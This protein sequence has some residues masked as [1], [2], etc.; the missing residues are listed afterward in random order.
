M[1]NAYNLIGKTLGACRLEQI[2]GQGGSSVVYL[3][4]Q[5]R[6]QRQVAV[7]IL[8]P[9]Q[10]MGSL[11]HQQFLKRFEHEA[12]IIARLDHESIIQIF[13]YNEQDGYAYLIMPYIAGGNLLKVLTA[14]GRLSPREAAGYLVQAADALDYAHANNVIHR[15]LKPANF[16][17]RQNGRLVL[18]DFGIARMMQNTSQGRDLTTPSLLLG[19][20]EYMAPEM[21]RGE[22]VDHYTDIYELGIVL[23][24]LLSG[25]L[26]FVGEMPYAILLQHMEEP[27]PLLHHVY[28]DI[29]PTVDEIIQR[30]T[31]K[32]R[33]DRFSSV[34][35]MA[36]E[37]LAALV[38]PHHQAQNPRYQATS[39]LPPYL[40][41][42]PQIQPFAP[43]LESTNVFPTKPIAAPTTPQQLFLPALTQVVHS[44]P[45]QGLMDQAFAS[46]A[47]R[48]TVPP[49]HSRGSLQ[50]APRKPLTLLAILAVLLLATIGTTVF[51]YA[52]AANQNLVSTSTALPLSPGQE[53]RA[54]TRQYYNDLNSRN[55]QAAFQMWKQNKAPSTYCSFLQGYART[56]H[57]EASVQFGQSQ[58][59]IFKV[60]L[61]LVATEVFPTTREKTTYTGYQELQLVDGLLKIIGGSLRSI[62]RV[63]SPPVL[64]PELAPDAPPT[65]QGQ[66][67][68]QQF[69]DSLNQR[70]YP[71]A[72]S[73]W[74]QDYHSQTPYCSFVG[75]YMST[76]HDDLQV[77]GLVLLGDGTVQVETTITA[78]DQVQNTR[79]IHTYSAT[80]TVG[81]EKSAW[82]I[83]GGTQTLLQ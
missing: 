38:T 71:A 60:P 19:T 43:T 49:P 48:S 47:T 39:T 73:L 66:A 68:I 59:S 63:P 56:E 70:D 40:S 26:P 21:A 15:D 82:K 34:G 28:P 69:Y 46:S 54:V 64:Q 22:P 6:P 45:P 32:R 37:L 7:K 77:S 76:L 17:L 24:Q 58:G 9:K 74:G 51:A 36:Q 53:A 30:A 35:Q 80:Y 81:L 14:R 8:L 50:R 41:W 16:L 18:S 31:A 44:P 79:A 4:Q 61:T 29:P 10:P 72:Y 33:E 1:E 42:Q 67:V 57:I 55:Y 20:P 11:L 5:L 12:D 2:I 25:E 23:Y 83:L 65:Q 3:S 52:H 78:R 27:V 75:G 62:Q 13:E